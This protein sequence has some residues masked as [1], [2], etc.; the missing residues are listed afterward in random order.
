MQKLNSN[1]LLFISGLMVI[2]ISFDSFPWIV[3]IDSVADL[4]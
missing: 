2:F 4:H 1:P 3:C